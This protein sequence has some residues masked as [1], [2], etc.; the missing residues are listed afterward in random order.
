MKTLVTG[1]TG[2]VGN[3]LIEELLKHNYKV[4]CLVRKEIKLNNQDKVNLVISDITNKRGVDEAV[5]GKDIVFHLVGIGNI[6]ALSRNS[7]EKFRE[8]NVEGTR[9]VLD[10][11]EKYK[12]KKIVYLSST[13]AMGLIK[14]PIINE[15]DICN[16]KTPYQKSK[17][18]SEQLIKEYIQRYNLPVIILRPT[19]IYGPRMK[20]GQILKIY[21]IMKRGFFPFVDGGNATI[22]AVHVKDVVNAIV[23]AA[24]NGRVG[25]TYILAGDDN[26]NL[27]EIVSI[28]Q[29]KGNLKVVKI[30]LP[31]SFLKI[32]VF[33]LQNLSL[34]ININPPMTLQRLNSFT[35]N[36]VFDISKAKKEL[37]WEPKIGIEQGLEETVNYFMENEKQHKVNKS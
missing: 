30:N 9:N 10:A 22:P 18:E 1:A 27:R 35:F 12:V 11:C 32:P 2:F 19:M 4:T 33:I 36:R 17:Y 34:I 31:K 21:K 14:K 3:Y 20:H 37:K 26:K 15:N 5:K 23:A 28:I 7:Y 16:P 24:K 13:A 6:S 29:I 25:E 8:I